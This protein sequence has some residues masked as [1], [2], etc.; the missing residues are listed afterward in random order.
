M[1]SCRCFVFPGLQAAV[2]NDINILFLWG[3]KKKQEAW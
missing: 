1:T 3:L 2:K